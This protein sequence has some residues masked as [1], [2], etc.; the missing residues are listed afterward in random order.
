MEIFFNFH[1]FLLIKVPTG[2]GEEYFA[3]KI[4]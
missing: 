1:A 2:Q 4:K 3:Y